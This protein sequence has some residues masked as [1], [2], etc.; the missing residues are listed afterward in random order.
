V[1]DTVPLRSSTEGHDEV[2]QSPDPNASRVESVKTITASGAPGKRYTVTTG[3]PSSVN[4]STMTVAARPCSTWYEA[5][6]RSCGFVLE[7]AVQGDDTAEVLAEILHHRVRSRVDV[8]A[9]RHELV[10]EPLI[11]D[12]ADAL[13]QVVDLDLIARRDRPWLRRWRS[14]RHVVGEVDVTANV[15][16][17]V[18]PVDLD[19]MAVTEVPQAHGHRR[20][21]TLEVL[22]ETL[23]RIEKRVID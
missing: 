23:A 21:A 19:P 3:S 4:E 7:L 6:R 2:D 9:Q 11:A 22:N 10:G 8:D 18:H 17:R 16:C 15:V 14:A 12:V 1:H 5:R 20:L 13:H